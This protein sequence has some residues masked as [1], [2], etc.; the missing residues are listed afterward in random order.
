M[1]LNK[2]VESKK[3]SPR[4]FKLYSLFSSEL[5]QECLKDMIEETFMEEPLEQEFTGV[6]FAFYDGRRSLIRA[7]KVTVEKV[8]AI[9]KESN[10]DGQ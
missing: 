4:E 10:Y 3:I 2:L 1:D 5:G 7:M 8:R 9:I 6:R